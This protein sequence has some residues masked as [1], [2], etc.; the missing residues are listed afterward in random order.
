MPAATNL[1]DVRVSAKATKLR[2]TL[3]FARPAD[4]TVYAAND[5]IFE[6]SDPGVL[7]FT[8]AGVS[9]FIRGAT[10][11]MNQVA[12]T[13]LLLLIFDE[14]PTSFADNA[15]VA[16]VQ[17]DWDKLVAAFFLP[18]ADKRSAAAT[19]RVYE[20]AAR[21][22]VAYTASAG[23]KLYGLLVTPTG[24]TPAAS[25]VFALSIHLEID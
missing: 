11:V 17:A 21:I 13:D 25:V 6:S 24:F 10:C 4:T 7:C 15:S 23:G 3:S 9:G 1:S 2:S 14:E 12:A 20:T 5:V 8:S 18:T 16:L 19:V 22:P